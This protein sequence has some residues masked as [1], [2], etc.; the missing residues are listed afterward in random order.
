MASITS[1]IILA[2]RMTPVLGNI[3]NGMER[4]INILQRADTA[5]DN[6]FDPSQI[7][8]AGTAVS[9]T[10][11]KLA[12][13]EEQ[14]IRNTQ[15]QTEF[16]N[17]IKEGTA[18]TS[19]LLGKLAGLAGAYLGISKIVGI[20]DTITQTTA[21]LNMI[22]D[23]S[24]TT[25]GLEDKIFASAQR[26]RAEYNATAEVVAKL[27]QR[28]GSIWSSNDE[29]IQFAENLNKQFVIAGASQQEMRSAS[30]QL[31][32]AL[33]SGVLRGEELNAVF[34]SAPNIIQT[35]ADY[36]NVPIGKIRELASDGQ[37]SAGIV[38]NALL[39]ATDE[40]NRQFESMPYTWAQ[41]FTMASNIALKAIRPLLRGISWLANNISI[42]GPAV[43]GLGTAF[44][45]FQTAAHWTQIATA[46]TAIYHGVV[47]LLSIGFGILTGNTAAASAAVYKF[48]SALLASPIT[49]AVMV[50]AALIGVLY[51]GVA[52]VN[53]FA[54]TSVSATGIIAGA[55]YTLGAFVYNIMVGFLN[56]FSVVANF[57][58]NVFNDPVA[59]LK[60]LFYDLAVTVLGYFSA[61]AHGIEDLVNQIPRVN[62]NLSSGV[63]SLMSS[64][65][66]KS[67]A[68]KASSGWKEYEPSFEY[69]NYKDA[70]SK[71]Y[72]A[73]EGL[74]NKIS[75]NLDGVLNYGS[76]AGYLEDISNDTGSIADSVSST[77]EEMRYLREI[78]E[79]DAINRFTTAEI[80]VDMSGMNNNITNGLDIDGVIDHMANG[81]SEALEMAAEG[82]HAA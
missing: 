78:A 68:I 66:D 65:S 4:T 38:K 69:M 20:S 31:T 55:F 26:S 39:G 42:I 12:E 56:I 11:L 64:L 72:T 6:A 45:V 48:N 60:I 10:N 35:I 73:G 44:L 17:E 32:Q 82:V 58:R 37:I 24:Q 79:R 52:A 40:I 18:S 33:G 22:N 34:E 23:G 15:R 81:A 1:T 63:D 29:T 71:G 36:M 51:A 53:K 67:A 25:T 21:R 70:F 77:E 9:A 14:L 19:G 61:I 43:L 30:L 7:Y 74:A 54:G 3:I 41:V 47:E 80:K 46:A 50:I 27:A 5:V 62:V 28:A 49:W 8:A 13:T 16:N 57:L 75:G 59:A 2:D 76:T